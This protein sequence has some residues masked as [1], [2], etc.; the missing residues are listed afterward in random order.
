MVDGRILLLVF[1]S[2]P[3]IP[4]A[5][6]AQG[7]GARWDVSVGVGQDGWRVAVAHSRL[8]PSWPFRLLEVGGLL[9]ATAYGGAPAEFTLR[10]GDGALPSQ[11]TLDPNIYALMAGIVAE[12]PLG[13]HLRVGMNLDLVGVA[14]GPSRTAGTLD[15]SPA[16]LSLFR[17][18]NA[19]RGSLN[20]EFYIASVVSRRFEVR[21]GL[22]HYATGYSVEGAAGTS[23][24]YQRF[25]D[26][27]FVAVR[28]RK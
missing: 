18:G 26:A 13:W 16:T 2:F 24:A 22:S 1:C 27:F 8:R 9:R 23:G 3:A 14:A 6:A 7:T 15:A 25:D 5:A 19:D 28:V 11:L 12:V 21:G 10:G 17:Y 4:A 20:S